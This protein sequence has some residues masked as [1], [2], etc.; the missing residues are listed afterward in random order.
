MSLRGHA[1]E[2]SAAAFS[3]DGRQIA[4]AGT[5]GTVR[6]WDF[7]APQE[8]PRLSG[9]PRRSFQRVAFGGD[10]QRLTAIT[11]GLL[12]TWELTTSR[13]LFA[14]EFGLIWRGEY[15]TSVLSRDGR[16]LACGGTGGG[17]LAVYEAMTG[18]EVFAQRDDKLEWRELAFSPD[19]RLL[20]DASE[21]GW[22]RVRDAQTGRILQ[23]LQGHRSEWLKV[24][25]AFSPDGSRL[26][27]GGTAPN[28]KIWDTGSWQELHSLDGH[29]S[30]VLCLAF[31]HDSRYLASGGLFDKKICVWDATTGTKMF[32]LSGH[33]DYVS[34]VTF[35]PD[36]KRLFSG[37]WDGSINVWDVQNRVKLL[38]L[39]HRGEFVAI[40]PDGRRLASC[41]SNARPKVQVW[42]S[43]L[44]SREERWKRHQER[45][46]FWQPQEAGK[47][48]RAPVRP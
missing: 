9:P 22:V 24:R 17:K 30:Q 1:G 36:K 7:T 38:T 21:K 42:E 13:K 47:I 40:S 25:L 6:L 19:G 41:D 23:T 31:S 45:I 5:D 20:A 44:L 37:G 35:S 8:G 18:K 34:S 39:H 2:V 26:V 46:P 15:V 4:S 10:S 14:Q 29:S 11:P 28:V 12:L 48:E 3:P 43:E 32:D 16:Y 27:S 33:A